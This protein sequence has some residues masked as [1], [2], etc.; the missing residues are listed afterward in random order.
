MFSCEFCEISKNNF[1]HRTP[2]VAAFKKAANL[3][4]K[5]SELKTQFYRI[6]TFFGIWILLDWTGISN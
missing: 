6:S 5:D 4:K 2:P 1:S 3:L